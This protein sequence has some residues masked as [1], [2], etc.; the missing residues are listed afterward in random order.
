[1]LPEAEAD[2]LEAWYPKYGRMFDQ[3]TPTRVVHDSPPDVEDPALVTLW[4]K[5]ESQFKTSAVMN[6]WRRV[7]F[8]Q[9]GHGTT[10]GLVILFQQ[11]EGRSFFAIRIDPP[12]RELAAFAHHPQFNLSYLE[13]WEGTECIFDKKI[14][15][16]C[17]RLLDRPETD[18]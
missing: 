16:Y 4:S 10:L 18:S 5:I 8:G 13:N 6:G 15:A 12:N 3:V 2:T 1:M 9:M 11:T 14:M 17:M 7:G